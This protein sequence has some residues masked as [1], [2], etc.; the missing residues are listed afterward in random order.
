LNGL[1]EIITV[2][3]KKVDKVLEKGVPGMNLVEQ[4]ACFFRYG[5]DKGKRRL[6]N[7][8]LAAEEGIAMAGEAVKGFTKRDLEFFRKISEEKFRL[9]HQT[10]LKWAREEAE[11]RA[12]EKA[13][14]EKLEA[15]REL[16]ANGVSP[17]LIAASLKLRPEELAGL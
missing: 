10:Q 3:L 5:G 2:E 1:T 16:K 9:D 17:E 4:W 11:E 14:Q 8:I 6:I 12:R 7:E 13:Y 15:A